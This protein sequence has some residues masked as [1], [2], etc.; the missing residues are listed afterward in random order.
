[1]A[2]GAKLTGDR[3]V[4][5][6]RCTASEWRGRPSAPVSGGQHTGRPSIGTRWDDVSADSSSKAV[7]AALAANV[8]IALAKL[9]AF[10]FTGSAS[11]L[12]ET[13]HSAGDS[14]NEA[15]LLRG[16]AVARRNPTPAHPLGFGRSRYFWPF[17]VAIVLFTLGGVLSIIEA[18]QKFI[19][20]HQIDSPWWAFAVL[21]VG[22]VLESISLRTAAHQARQ[23]RGTMSWWG[24]IR[25]TRAA[26]LPVVLLEDTGAVIGL[27]FAMVGLGLAVIT[28]D[29]RWDAAGSGAIGLLLIVIA[30]VLARETHSLLIGESAQPEDLERIRRAIQDTPGIV[31]VTNLATEHLAPEEILVI[32]TVRFAADLGIGDARRAVACATKCVELAVPAARRVFISIDPGSSSD[33]G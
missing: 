11:M 20:P 28:D 10:I 32:A 21:A 6:S 29:P 22:M 16:Q 4:I 24:F 31:D 33:R 23:S 8:G 19:S 15:L 2:F 3:R 5:E 18:V 13:F 17:V 1:M 14:A 26:E 7:W 9:V 27:S 12:A 25:R 30:A